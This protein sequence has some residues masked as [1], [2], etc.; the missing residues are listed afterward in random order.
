MPNFPTLDDIPISGRRVLVRADLNVPISDGEISDDTRIRGAA[1]TIGELAKKGARVIV[2]SHFGRPRGKPDPDLSL[3]P[4]A[5]VLARALNGRPVKFCSSWRGSVAA[6][7]VAALDDGEVL[8]LENLRFD[9]GE[10]K[11]DPDFVTALAELGDLYVNDAFSAAHRAHASTEGLAHVLPAVAGRLMEREIAALESALG[12]P[13]HPVAAIVGG[14]K[15]STKIAVLLHLID[16]VDVLIIGGAMANTFLAADGRPV[17]RSLVEKD[18]TE[19]AREI[20]TRA[21]ERGCRLIL[22]LDS[23]VAGKLAPGV[24]TR[25]VAI[26]GVGAEDMILDI[27][28]KSVQAIRTELERCHTLLWNGPLGAFEVPPFDAATNAIATAVAALTTTSGL[29]S[30][31]GGGDTVAALGHAE[32]LDRMTYVSS[33]GGAFLEWI[34]GRDLPGIAALRRSG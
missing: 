13:R 34:E 21:R 18:M 31:A 23:V 28:P 16:K 17:G 33:A 32:M 12:N 22:P 26:D 1:E 14:A 19:T 27:G 4:V 11:N 6:T 3:E 5:P 20:E 8:L 15:V 10:E 30:V 7:A 29:V 25:T 2:L 24:A 9:P